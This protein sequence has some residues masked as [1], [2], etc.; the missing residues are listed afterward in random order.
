MKKNSVFIFI[1]LGSVILNIILGYYFYR[2]KSVVLEESANNTVSL[3]KKYPFL[4]K[5]ILIEDP[6]DHLIS[7]LRLRNQLEASVRPWEDDFS[8][9]FEYLPTGTSIAVNE[10]NEH[11]VASLFKVP[12]VM[13]YYHYLKRTGDSI[14]RE[15]TIQ[16][17]DIH[18]EFSELWQRG[19]GSKV[20]MREA[21]ELALTKSDNTAIK[22]IARQIDEKDFDEVYKAL[23]LDLL[24]GE[25][26]AIMT[27]R[28]Y[29]IILQ[30]LYFASVLDKDDSNEILMYL[31]NSKFNDKLVAGVGDDVKVAHKIGVFKDA[32]GEDAYFDCGIVY[33][34]KRPYL[35]CMSSVGSEDVAKIRMQKISKIVY[36]YVKSAN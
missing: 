12:L 34:P 5:R 36:E 17:Q 24:S 31:T 3:S 7:F 19:V 22:I 28:E 8:F 25:N 32:K 18:T 33:L 1:L 15:E 27:T 29:S 23:D 30:A 9:Y 20:T 26:G 10:D 13:A 35:L 16:Q 2:N 14:D 6:N 4:S 21:I 11:Y